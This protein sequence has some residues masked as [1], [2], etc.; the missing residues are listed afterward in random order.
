[1]GISSGQ[2]PESYRKLVALA[3]SVI[4][5][6]D[7][8]EAHLTTLFEAVDYKAKT[9][10]EGDMKLVKYL[11]FINSGFVRVYRNM[12]GSD[13]TTHINCP[14]GF[15]TS[16]K[17]FLERRPSDEYVSCIT[18][19]QLLRIGRDELDILVNKSPKWA[20]FCRV[21]TDR[22]LAYNEQRTADM[23]TLTA[24]QRYEKLMTTQPDICLHVPLQY[25]AS[26]LGMQPQS[27]SRIRKKIIS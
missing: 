8:E 1:M 26:Y 2:V 4:E 10:L 3:S 12:D 27:L 21:I 14:P 19:C 20:T 9:L 23:L 18:D 11:Y 22:S 17:N 25:I 5:L 13:V 7:G 6:E 15:I 24:G 16:F